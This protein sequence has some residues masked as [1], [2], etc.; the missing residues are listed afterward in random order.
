MARCRLCGKYFKI[1][2]NTHLASVHKC[3]L[4]DYAK[5]F[6]PK[7]C[8][9]L[10]PNLLPKNDPRYIKWKESLK[11][12]PSPWN[13]GFTKETHSSVAKISRTFK[14][15][16]ID[17]FTRWRRKMIN[18]G[19]IKVNY[20]PLQRSGDLAE[21]IGVI[22][23]DGYIGK[24]PRTEVLAIFSN[25]NNSGFVRRY[26][27]L[28]RKVFNK[29]PNIYKRKDSNCIKISIYQKDLSKRLGI[30]AGPRKNQDI[31]IPHWILR[32]KEYL[33]RYLRGLYEAEGSFCIHKP[34]YTY[35]FLFANRNKSLLENVYRI[36][37]ILGF[38]PHKSKYKI[39]I[40][41]KEEVYKIRELI[42][43]RQY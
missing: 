3:T 26:S 4:R 35:K 38:H 28:I 14:R 6:G 24:F 31:K 10:S 2:T 12:R 7:N 20:S 21:L 15:E 9:F 5:K 37:K 40:S 23:G 29:K 42:K 30:S 41:K 13:K 36:L 18:Q 8:G 22:L 27:Q 34:T 17:N 11:K 19:L 39:Q 33:K 16:K 1:I 25:S 32:N 43:F